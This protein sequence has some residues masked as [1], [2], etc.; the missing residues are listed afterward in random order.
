MAEPLV[1][2]PRLLEVEI[3]VAKFKR[4]KYRRSDQIPVE[5]IKVSNEI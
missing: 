2:E 4:Y 3:P 5:F 1:P